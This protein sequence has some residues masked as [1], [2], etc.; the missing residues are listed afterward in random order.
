[1]SESKPIHVLY[2]EDDAGLARL[3]Q[4]KLE[5]AGYTV[6]LARDGA[7]GLALYDA[8][9]HDIVAVDQNMPVYDGLGVIRVLASRGPLPPI[10][11]VTG[12]GDEKIAAEAL[13][14]G[15]GDYIVKDADGG[16][17]ELLPSVIEQVLRQHYLVEEKRRAEEA[18]QEANARLDYLLRHFVPS[19]VARR[20]MTQQE[21]PHLGGQRRTVSVLFAD[22]RGFT[23]LAEALE[24]EAMMD[25]LNRHFTTIGSL[26]AEHGGT[27]DQYVGDRVM[28]LFNAPDD[29]PDHAVR[30]VQAGL[31]VQRALRLLDGHLS[32][33]DRSIIVQ[34]GIG[35][36]TGPAVVGY[37]GFEDRF[38]Y[39]VIGDTIN[40]GA[41]LSDAAHSGEVLIGPQTL[42]EVHGRIRT[43]PV[44]PLRLK[45]KA[46]LVMVYEAVGGRTL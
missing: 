13:K 31:A 12:S 29:Q 46:A 11:M 25:L 6:T 7:E 22:I 16:Y 3:L 17:L 18:L 15:A 44:G 36:N 26:I 40:V 1:M 8:G 28:A 24:P 32:E 35:I 38:N 20:L 27:I 14:L 10:I 4:K 37:V 39:T 2:M 45:G 19:S 33:G 9:I 43:R 5:R 23:L 21:L 30:A 42:E 34:F 41:R